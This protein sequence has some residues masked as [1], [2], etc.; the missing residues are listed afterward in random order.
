M[1]DQHIEFR[2]QRE[3]GEIITDTFKFLR[4]NFKPLFTIILKI[5]GPVFLIL[6][7]ATGYYSYIGM[8][9]LESP[10]FMD[11]AD[12]D[13]GM[14]V[15][16]LF[17]LLTSLLAFY[18]LLYGVVFHFIRSYIENYGK[19][20]E[21]DV[22]EGVKKDF[23]GL[24]GLLLLMG[25]ITGFATMLCLLPGI[26]VWVPLSIAPAILTFARN[27]VFDS[28]SHS[29]D[30]IK[31]NW[32]TTFFS[33]V[34]ITLLVY[35]IGMVFQFPLMVYYFIKTLTSVQ[36]GSV[37]NPADLVDWVYVFFNVLSSL[38]Q[39]LLS[40]VIVVATAFIYFNLDEKKNATGSYERI[41]NLGTSENI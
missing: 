35:I 16:A 27:S 30:L 23:G 25:I 21:K 13:V 20:Q 11:T 12:M 15:I 17:I 37:A 34:V 36:E 26:Y 5:A 41:S 24:L 9:L 18:I 4:E 28:I 38:F 22:Y 19:V 7:L 10:F 3:L 8:D 39:Y 1:L 2:Q 14:Y 31:D 40:T 6:L 29:F 33:L 32:W